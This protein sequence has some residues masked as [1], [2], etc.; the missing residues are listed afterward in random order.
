M[1]NQWHMMVKFS[2]GIIDIKKQIKIIF[3]Q[4]ENLLEFLM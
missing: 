3:I 1:E 4:R 2:V